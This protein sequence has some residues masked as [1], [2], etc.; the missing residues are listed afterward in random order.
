MIV[1]PRLVVT[2]STDASRRWLDE[3]RP[4]FLNRAAFEA[5]RKKPM[6]LGTTL[7]PGPLD[8]LVGL[9]LVLVPFYFVWRYTVWT[10]PWLPKLLRPLLRSVQRFIRHLRF[11]FWSKPVREHGIGMTLWCWWCLGSLVSGSFGLLSGQWLAVVTA[12]PLLALAVIWWYVLRWWRQRQFRPRPLPR[13]RQ[14]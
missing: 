6:P 5:T 1:R 2:P 12:L 10:F 8:T 9:S 7:T 14:L 13:R 11:Q 3:G 4:H